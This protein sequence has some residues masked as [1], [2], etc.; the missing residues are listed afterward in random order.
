MGLFDLDMSRPEGAGFNSALLAAAQAL[1]TP[2]AQGGGMGAAFGAIPQAME[3]AKSQA[4]KESMFGME[5]RKL[6]TDFAYGA[7]D[8]A[9]AQRKRAELQAM[10]AA[11]P[12]DQKA[13]AMLN[14][15]KYVESMMPKQPKVETIYT[16]DG[17]E[18]KAW[19]SAPGA[20][21]VPVGGVK[22]V[23][24]PWE[25]EVGPDGQPRMRSG[26]FDAKRRIAEAGAGKG[27]TFVQEKE[28]D[29]A[30]GKAF[31]EQYVKIQNAGLN[32]QSRIAKI[33]RM[34][35]LLN[36][37]ETGKFTPMMTEVKAALES[38]GIKVDNKL[39][40]AQAV[41]ALSNELALQARNT[42]DGAG[43]PGAM[44]DADR[45]FLTKTV[46]GLAKTP[47]GNRLL[48]ETH[49]RLAKRDAEV[50]KIARDYR[51]KNGKLDEGFYDEL[52]KLSESNPL[53]ADL[54]SSSSGYTIR[55]IR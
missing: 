23:Q 39:G 28:E 44:S 2:R 49:K 33:D 41:E 40:N 29:K 15:A 1:L 31:G 12:P 19:V 35:Q 24:P 37:L 50:A 16:P 54:E 34:E 6:D 36:G 43:M 48:I 25:Y 26:V 10:I 5:K 38:A 22:S 14:P 20:A 30:V 18:Q 55:R 4:M 52:H 7:E 27:A 46:P 9:E 47:A 8:R 51:K 21:P 17:R 42:S 53:F 32:S 13:L 45:V 11:L 3:R